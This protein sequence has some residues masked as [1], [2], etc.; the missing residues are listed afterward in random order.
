MDVT[1]LD[2]EMLRAGW[3]WTDPETIQYTEA[4]NFSA[5]IPATYR[6]IAAILSS[7][8]D[9]LE[10]RANR[11]GTVGYVGDRGDACTAA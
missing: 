4:P 5:G 2:M 7:M 3:H 6:R 1:G 9:E 10:T 11:Y 8:A